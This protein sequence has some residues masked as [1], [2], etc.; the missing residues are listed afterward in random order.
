LRLASQSFRNQQAIPAE[1]TCDG[2]GT[3]EELHWSGAP[4]GTQSFALVLFD[5]DARPPKGFVHWVAY[6]IPASVHQ[7]AS[8]K[9]DQAA[10]PGG[11]VEGNNGRGSLGFIPS[12]PGPGAP[13]H[14]TFTLY[15][16]SVPSL[17]LPSGAT[18]DQVLEAV[19]GKVLAQTELVGLYQRKPKP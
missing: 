15:A 13:H 19:K 2:A 7:I 5:P 1:H 14:Y 6:D 9:Y 16:L 18:R 8:G 10:L 3:S 17:G 4:K 11:G 12:C